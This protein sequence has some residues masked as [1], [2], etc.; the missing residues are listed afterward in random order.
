MLLNLMGDILVV[1]IVITIFYTLFLPILPSLIAEMLI[2][3]FMPV[4][5]MLI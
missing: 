4:S 3:D 1:S 2:P 5:I